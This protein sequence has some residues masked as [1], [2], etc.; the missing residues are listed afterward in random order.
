MLEA[1]GWISAISLAIC[2]IPQGVKSIQDKHSDGISWLF[3]ILW[4]IGEV[5]GLIYVV[6]LAK[7]PLILNYTVNVVFTSVI[8]YYKVYPRKDSSPSD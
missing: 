8:L 6:P 7:I 3:I 4:F 2:S 5:T 1:I